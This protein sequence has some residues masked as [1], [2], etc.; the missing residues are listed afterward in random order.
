MIKKENKVK[1]G[2][3]T[4][5]LATATALASLQKVLN[6]KLNIKN[7]DI[8]TPIKTL[9]IIIKSCKMI[10]KNKAESSSVKYPYNDPDVTVGLDIVSTVELCDKKDKFEA[11]I[12]IYGGKGVGIITKPGLQIPIGEAAI[13]PIPRKMIKENLEKILPPNKVAKVIISI[14]NGEQISSKTMNPRLGIVNGISILGTTGIARSMDN[15]A[16]KNSIVTQID[17]AIAENV[18]NLVFVPGNIGEKL[19]LKDL[20]VKKG[21]IIQTGNFIGFMFEEAKKRGISSFTLFGHIGK[22]VKLAGGIFNTKHAVAD[23]RCEIF[24]A[25]AALVGCGKEVIVKIFEAK[26]TEEIINILKK[27]KLD[28]RVLNSIVYAIK[29]KCLNRFDLELNVII[30]DMEGNILNTNYDNKLIK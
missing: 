29:R 30:V 2:V 14:P 18:E 23:G 20:N 26:T 13:N 15:T 7:V 3:T 8:I 12:Q 1:T 4:G 27:E 25:H 17:V 24:A 6:Q 21:E 28:T 22:L 19:A 10:S 11:N 9:N 5:S 16:Y